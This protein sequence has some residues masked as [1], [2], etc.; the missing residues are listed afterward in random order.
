M[1]KHKTEHDPLEGSHPGLSRRAWCGEE[2][3]VP[4]TVAEFIDLREQLLAKGVAQEVVAT[5][6]AWLIDKWYT[7]ID[8]ASMPAK[9]RYRK[10]LADCTPPA[11]TPGR[12]LRPV[13]AGVPTWLPTVNI[14]DEHFDAAGQVLVLGGPATIGT[15]PII[16]DSVHLADVVPIR[17]I[18]PREVAA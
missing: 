8:R 13:G 5:L 11:P 2:A 3:Y 4:H 14:V 16:S 10:L 17:P 15:T 7:G 12:K 1:S 6:E 9:A 18:S